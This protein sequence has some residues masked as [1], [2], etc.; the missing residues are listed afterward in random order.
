MSTGKWE[1]YVYP[2]TQVLRNK[3]DIRDPADLDRFERGTTAIRIQEL[4]E[5]P[6]RG[7]FD[8]QH[9]KAI[10]KQVFKDVYEW[11]G[12]TRTV[13]IVKGSGAN[14]TLFA[15]TENI[16][17]FGALA[18]DIIKEANY[19][20]GQT[21]QEFAKTV[22]EVYAVVNEMHPFREGNG[23]A[24]RE[25]MN[26]LARQSGHQFDYER[27][28]K[29]VWNEAAKESAHNNLAPMREVFY[30]ITTVERAVAFDKLQPAEALAK[31][32]EL[33]GAIKTLLQARAEGRDESMVRADISRDL[34]AG[35]SVPSE[36]TM[37]ESARVIDRAAKYR[38]LM[39]REA[40][41]LGG[42][43]KGEVVGVSTHHALLKVGD[44]IAVR[45]ERENLDR[46]IY[47]GEKVTIQYAANKSQV[48]EQGRE[49]KQERGGRDM[50]M[51]K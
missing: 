42:D 26:E 17:K 36:V 16:P 8:L 1:D 40:S 41:E 49:P 34:H 4:R 6:V 45:Y 2:G 47:P 39:V 22:T 25:F 29:T 43:Y 48:Y 20:R 7:D 35:R 24:T 9:L 31:H 38:G 33:D 15:F 32:P 51:A 14:Q 28:D 11:A 5:S 37:D 3:A 12:D 46:N 21:K 23:R 50:E 18:H 30:E 44:M 19:G 27:V 13:D 10:H